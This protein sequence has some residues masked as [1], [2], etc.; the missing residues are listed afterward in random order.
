ML[1]Q[2]F[3]VLHLPL[4]QIASYLINK[5]TTTIQ[6]HFY[7]FDSD[8]GRQLRPFRVQFQFHED[9]GFI[10]T[11]PHVSPHLEVY[12]AHSR[13]QINICWLG[14]EKLLR[15]KQITPDSKPITG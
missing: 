10:W 15:V 9:K 11:V 3:Q 2:S 12:L 5:H 1:G 6:P 4:P 14:D 8:K 13:C 7:L